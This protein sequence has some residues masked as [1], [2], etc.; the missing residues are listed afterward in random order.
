MQRAWPPRVSDNLPMPTI[1][2]RC[3]WQSAGQQIVPLTSWRLHD[4]GGRSARTAGW[5]IRSATAMEVGHVGD[6]QPRLCSRSTDCTSPATVSESG[7]IIPSLVRMI[8]EA[9][10][11]QQA[12]E[13]LMERVKAHGLSDGAGSA[14]TFLPSVRQT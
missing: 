8:R 3:R 4:S 5:T 10:A 2:S 11:D 6:S 7:K 1:G 13:L 14:A 12:L 9:R